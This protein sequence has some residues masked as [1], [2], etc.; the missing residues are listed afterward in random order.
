[1]NSPNRTL[2]AQLF[3][4]KNYITTISNK[5]L[6]MDKESVD[7]ATRIIGWI[8]TCFAF[9]GFFGLLAIMEESDMPDI[10]LGIIVIVICW[11]GWLM[12]LMLNEKGLQQTDSSAMSCQTLP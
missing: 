12:L 6:S 10:L 5:A 2:D 4:Q 11:L 8:V 7:T 3:D 9:T 1:M